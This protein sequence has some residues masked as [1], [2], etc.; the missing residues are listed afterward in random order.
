MENQL[1]AQFKPAK[2]IETMIIS[3]KDEMVN[4]WKRAHRP[5]YTNATMVMSDEYV[6]VILEGYDNRFSDCVCK[7]SKDVWNS[8][9]I[10]KFSEALIEV[11]SANQEKCFN[12]PNL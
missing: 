2:Q 5:T 6:E 3:T 8:I 9:N 10:R 7:I 1:L 4:V 12:N 11:L